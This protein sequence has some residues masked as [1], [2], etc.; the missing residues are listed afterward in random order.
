[1]AEQNTIKTTELDRIF[2][3]GVSY[4]KDCT[5]A[6]DGKPVNF[7]LKVIWEGCTLRQAMVAA[8]KDSVEDFG[9]NLRPKTTTNAKNPAAVESANKLR[10]AKILSLKDKI[11]DLKMSEV[12]KRM[13]VT[14]D[15]M[16]TA[17]DNVD[18]LKRIM[19]IL[20]AKLDKK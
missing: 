8:T 2:G 5:M 20:Q 3:E 18:E 19:A 1:M 9:N 15:E 17:I 12:G 16:V 11:T 10:K 14:V 7:K 4:I 6:V 13:E